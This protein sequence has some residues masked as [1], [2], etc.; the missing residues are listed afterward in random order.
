MAGGMPRRRKA[1]GCRTC[2]MRH[3]K[4]DETKPNCN[5]CLKARRRCLGYPVTTDASPVAFLVMAQGSNRPECDA[6]ARRAFQFFYEAC[7]SSLS[8]HGNTAVWTRMVLQTSHYEESIKHL[9]IAAACLGLCR[10]FGVSSADEEITFL[11][12]HGK[13]L[14]LLS[15]GQWHNPSVILLACLLLVLCGQLQ[16]RD[17]MA[18]Q[19]AKAGKKIL[20]SYYGENSHPGTGTDPLIDEIAMIF[21]RLNFDTPS[22]IQTAGLPTDSPPVSTTSSP[23][24]LSAK[25]NRS[26]LSLDFSSLP[27]MSQPAPPSNTLLI[28][29]L[30]DNKIFHP[31]SLATIRQHINEIAPLNSFSPLKSLCRII[32]SFYDTDSAIRVRQAIDGTAILGSSVAKC[33]FGEPTPIGDEKK[34]LDRPDAGRLFFISPPP[35]PPVG[36][37]MKH[38]D[39]PNRE[40]HAEDL[41]SKLQ[42]LSGKL[43]TATATATVD[44]ENNEDGESKPQYSAE[45]LQRLKEYRA[46]AALPGG[47]STDN[48][49]S[50]PSPIKHRSR[51]S[52]LIYD[53]K[54]H[55]DSPGLPAVMLEAEDESDVEL[56]DSGTKIMAHTPRPPVELMEH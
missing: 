30:E 13:A 40:V 16:N 35:S 2:I 11:F 18:A 36:W 42:K 25:R 31:A 54:A 15:R 19:H 45:A 17:D 50:A 26:G 20:A 4:C 34:Y 51:S 39:P 55:G 8:Q 24:S 43:G 14:A 44:E 23:G 21:S 38:E 28:T 33:Y 22:P 46:R 6:K 41:A 56:E 1:N 49:A 48:S 32:C 7:A 12:H 29:R 47:V 5:R 10:R 3:V 52:T 27:P 53:P 37:E 9:V